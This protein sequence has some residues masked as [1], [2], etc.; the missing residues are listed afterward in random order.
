MPITPDLKPNEFELTALCPVG[1]CFVQT[2]YAFV[3]DL[4]KA[5]ADYR[6]MAKENMVK[7]M[8]EAHKEGRHKESQ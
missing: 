3:N 6:R 1:A 4:K 5:S 2:T 8:T 7:N